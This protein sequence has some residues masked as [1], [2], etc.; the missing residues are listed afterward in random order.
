VGVT[1]EGGR[2]REPPPFHGALLE[3]PRAAGASLTAGSNKW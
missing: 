3:V 2:E 1:L